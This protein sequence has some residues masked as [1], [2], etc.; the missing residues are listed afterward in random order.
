MKNIIDFNSFNEGK[1]HEKG[2]KKTK[3]TKQGDHKGTM[4]DKVE[5]HVKSQ[6]CQTKQVGNDLEIHCNKEHIGQVMFRDDYVGVKEVGKKF[7]EEFGY[8]EFGKI[9]SAI[10]KI[11][12]SV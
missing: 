8:D 12:K 5:N 3:E 4:R 9:K 1:L 10:S 6:K 7:A 2:Q 11:I